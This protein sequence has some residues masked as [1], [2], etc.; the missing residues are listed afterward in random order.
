MLS[1]QIV[2]LQGCCLEVPVC[3][4]AAYI[5]EVCVCVYIY[6]Y[7]YTSTYIYTHT[8][9][10]HTCAN[11]YTDH[12]H[13]WILYRSMLYSWLLCSARR[14]KSSCPALHAVHSSSCSS[15][16]R[17]RFWVAALHGD[18]SRCGFDACNFCFLLTLM[19]R[20]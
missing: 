15:P 3:A 13:T 14:V 20:C 8:H 19:R 12:K 18:C 17:G 2:S 10:R 9:D 5:L 11:T 16:S 1:G 6:I 4:E 7:M